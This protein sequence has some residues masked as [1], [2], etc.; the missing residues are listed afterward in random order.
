M[1]RPTTSRRPPVIGRRMFLAGAGAVAG[2]VVLAA[3]SGGGS[4]SGSD[5]TPASAAKGK[6]AP[7]L[8]DLVEQGQLP[9]VE[10]RLPA[11][12]LVVEPNDRIGQYGGIWQSAF[13]GPGD[14]TGIALSTMYEGLVRWVPDWTG[15]PGDEEIIANVASSYEV[16]ADGTEYTFHLREGM[17][18]SDGEPFTAD[19]IAFG[20]Q[21]IVL[22]AELPAKMA[23]DKNAYSSGGVPATLRV[24][25]P[26]TV[27][28]VFEQPN[29]LFLPAL[30]EAVT[31]IVPKHYLQQFHAA[32]NPDVAALVAAE[33]Q[34]S[35]VSL[36]ALKVDP[37]MNADIPVIF[38]WKTKTPVGAGTRVELERNPYYWKVD[39][40]GSQLPYLDG[41]SFQVIEDNEVM[42]AGALQGDFDMHWRNFNTPT[43]KPLL[44][45]ARE[46]AGFDFFELTPSQANRMSIMLNLTHQ[47]PVLREV[48]ANK[49][50][51]IGLSHAI[52]RQQLI[53][54]VFQRQGTPSQ[55]APRE[56]SPFYDEEMTT[57]YTEYDVDLANQH[58]DAAGFSQRDDAGLR[59]GPDGQ[60]IRF[61]VSHA[62]VTNEADVLDLIS[63][64]WAEVGI[65]M[66]PEGIERTLLEERR[67]A[68]QH[69]AI[70]WPA[71]G[72]VDVIVNPHWYLPASNRSD[73]AQLWAQWFTSGGAEGE[74]PPAE[75]QQQYEL[76]RELQQ[77]PA[78][79]QQEQLMKEILRLAAEQFFHIGTVAAGPGYGIVK[80]SF[81][82]VPAAV[83]DSFRA[84]SPALTNPEQYFTQA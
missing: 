2:S 44:A 66:R 19:D 29:G 22:N 47:N 35:W 1:N 80:N 23:I 57:Q 11:E 42:L 27:T 18:W 53:D 54:T 9:P 13:N 71:G 7:Q 82:N 15:A 20:Y 61:L 3:C 67:K 32:H 63:G 46:D 55:V 31:L 51:R 75:V 43:N 81:H 77:T 58:L 30:A 8:A 41:V 12:P 5:D 70:A 52:D 60:P 37:T 14:Q 74:A 40:G 59:L 28:F 78:A 64:Y 56:E 10:E 76:Y 39:P 17:K 50:F 84:K 4:G 72:G 73:Y 65:D 79:D 48:F 45:D 6:E 26:L 34:D 21:D 36:F 68:N 83:T 38:P 16:D 25:D 49:D 24:D 33:G 69:D 62:G